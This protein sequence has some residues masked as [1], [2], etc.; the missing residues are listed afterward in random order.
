[1]QKLITLSSTEAELVETVSASKMVKC[2]RS[3][4]MEI[5]GLKYL[6]PTTLVEDNQPLS[7]I[8]DVQSK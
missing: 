5:T 3:S 1:M 2:V 6:G 4:M 8:L 7:H